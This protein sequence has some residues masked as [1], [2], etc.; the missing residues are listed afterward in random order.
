MKG[1]PVVPNSKK[2][3]PAVCL[4]HQL[5]HCDITKSPCGEVWLFS[6]PRG[7]GGRS[8]IDVAIPSISAATMLEHP[9]DS[10]YGVLTKNGFGDAYYEVKPEDVD[11][12]CAA[13]RDADTKT[14]YQM[15][16]DYVP[17]YC[18][19]CKKCYSHTLWRVMPI[20]DDGFYDCT[21]VTCPKVHT[22]RVLD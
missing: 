7:L 10:P 20:M 5:F 3:S 19:K 14:L 6:L 1:K 22:S 8:T 9:H 2:T 18:R 17:F 12:L 4:A 16:C 15:N 13:I 11:A 21:E